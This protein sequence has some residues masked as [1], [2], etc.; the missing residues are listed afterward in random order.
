[1]QLRA[2]AQQALLN[3]SDDDA[4]PKGRMAP[5]WSAQITGSDVSDVQLTLVGKFAGFP[6]SKSIRDAFG[7]AV[8][9]RDELAAWIGSDSAVEKETR[10]LEI[11][12]W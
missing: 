4:G 10:E 2:L 1:M 8:S 11:A 6:T 5:F 12:C 7:D 3:N 9:A